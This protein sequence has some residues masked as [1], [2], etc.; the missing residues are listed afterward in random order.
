MLKF[1]LASA[2][3]S[4]VACVG[5]FGVP[6]ALVERPITPESAQAECSRN[7]DEFFARVRQQAQS[8]L[9]AMMETRNTL[10]ASSADVENR[11]QEVQEKL[12]YATSAAEDF[13]SAWQ[14]D[15]FPVMIR[16]RAYTKADVEAQTSSLLAQID[17]YTSALSQ[18]TR[19]IA[20]IREHVEDLTVQIVRTETD[21]G[22]LDSKCS[23]YKAT[24]SETAAAELMASVDAL[25]AENATVISASPVR[26]VDEMIRDT[27]TARPVSHSRA[28]TFLSGTP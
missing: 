16:G 20:D 1:T 2:V 14:Q 24:H 11:Q 7:P 22:L 23:V 13:R 10:R 25:F 15:N 26:S 8:D 5:Y 3:A 27:S 17:G 4:A 9:Q 21:L 18:Y 6:A 12:N 28:V 19:T